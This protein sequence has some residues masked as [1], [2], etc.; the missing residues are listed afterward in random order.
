MYYFPFAMEVK[1]DSPRQSVK[2]ILCVGKFEQRKNHHLLLQAI[3]GLKEQY[4]F[5]VKLVGEVS[6]KE[7]E[8]YMQSICRMIDQL[9]LQKHVSVLTNI[10]FVKMHELYEEADL[11]VLP[12]ANESASVS[13]LEAM[14]FGCPVICSDD[15]GTRFYVEPEKTGYWMKKNDPEDLTRC[16]EALLSDP[17]KVQQFSKNCL[18][19]LKEVHD[20]VVLGHKLLE[21][22]QGGKR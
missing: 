19:T 8:Q 12:S 15:N 18:E 21:I 3:S 13:Q 1:N 11:F 4:A 16:L 17:E 6:S 10:P 5:H 9:G 7:H 14:A 2:Q 20:P 22:A